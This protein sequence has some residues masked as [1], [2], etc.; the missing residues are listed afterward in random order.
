MQ[1]PINSRGTWNAVGT[2]T[3]TQGTAITMFCPPYSGV[4]GP[5]PAVAQ[6]YRLNADGTPNWWGKNGAITKISLLQYLCGSTSHQIQ[7]MRPRGFTTVS[8]DAAKNQAVI[9]ITADP[10]LAANYKYPSVSGATTVVVTDDGIDTGDWCAFQYADGTWGFDTVSSVSTLAITMT[11]T[12]P[13]VASPTIPK[14]SPFFL[15]GVVADK[16]IATGY[17]PTAFY[18]NASV[19]NT[20]QDDNGFFS[21]VHPGDPLLVQSNNITAA[22]FITMLSG[23]YGDR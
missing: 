4:D 7:I 9:N 19:V 12:L 2:T 16:D 23:Y 21:A 1:N 15:F 22:G 13:N 8:S 11:T 10:G 14:G 6:L 20:I 18:M 3:Q 5:A 17:A